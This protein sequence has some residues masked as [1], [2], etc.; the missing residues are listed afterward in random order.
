MLFRDIDTNG[1]GK[2]TFIEICEA[3]VAYRDTGT[4]GSLLRGMPATFT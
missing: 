4:P 2:A 3:L 1:D